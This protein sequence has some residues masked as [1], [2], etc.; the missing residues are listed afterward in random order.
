[1]IHPGWAI[2][3]RL[4]WLPCR[5]SAGQTPSPAEASGASPMGKAW[6]TPGVARP[7]GLQTSARGCS[8]VPGFPQFPQLDDVL[9]VLGATDLFLHRDEVVQAG[10][11][12]LHSRNR[13]R[14]RAN[15]E[16]I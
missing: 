11:R 8:W 4:V 10:D 7:R 5:D 13:N 9:D 16:L 2:S 12:D 14:A 1:M 6:P 15:H 3:K